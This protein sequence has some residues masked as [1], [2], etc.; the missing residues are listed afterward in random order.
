[1]NWDAGTSGKMHRDGPKRRMCDF[2]IHL[3]N[4]VV[5]GDL[6]GHFCKVQR[7]IDSESRYVLMRQWNAIAA[8]VLLVPC[9]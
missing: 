4:L 1:M 3:T 5:G 8:V 9:N 6:T 7:E 2:A